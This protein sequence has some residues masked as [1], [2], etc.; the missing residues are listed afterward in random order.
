MTNP[1]TTSAAQQTKVADL[2]ANRGDSEFPQGHRGEIAAY[3]PTVCT[4]K[5]GTCLSVRQKQI[6]LAYV[7]ASISSL[8]DRCAFGL[9]VPA[10]RPSQPN[11]PPPT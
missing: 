10:R 11:N 5:K 3:G 9:A 7:A 1:R 8:A 6:V 4:L 2:C